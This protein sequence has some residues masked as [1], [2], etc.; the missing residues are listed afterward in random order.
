MSMYGHQFDSG[1]FQVAIDFDRAVVEVTEDNK[2][3]VS[4]MLFK[5]IER[6]S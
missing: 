1:L 4:P 6:E 3:L 5:L 2:H